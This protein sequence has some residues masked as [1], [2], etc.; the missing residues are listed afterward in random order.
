MNPLVSD[1]KAT[2]KLRHPRQAAKPR[3]LGSR[4]SYQ[5]AIEV[6]PTSRLIDGGRLTATK[7][8]LRAQ[9][10]P[11]IPLGYK[12]W[13]SG[14]MLLFGTGNVDRVPGQAAIVAARAGAHAAPKIHG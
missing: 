5:P 9:H 11:R 12:P 14:D 13:S 7:S 6:A 3:D 10:G 1:K 2:T 4:P 8:R